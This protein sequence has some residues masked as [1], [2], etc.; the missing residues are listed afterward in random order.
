MQAEAF[1]F[2]FRLLRHN[3]APERTN[4]IKGGVTFGARCRGHKMAIK[5]RK[6]CEVSADLELMVD[7]AKQATGFLKAFA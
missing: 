7:Q 2:L 4:D 5:P 3:R 1:R 6:L